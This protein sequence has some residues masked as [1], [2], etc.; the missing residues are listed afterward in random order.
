MQFHQTHRISHKKFELL[1]SFLFISTFLILSACDQTFEP[2]KEN[3]QYN[4]NISGYLDASA[5]TQWVRV[6]TVRE[7]ID[8]PPN[9][10][11][12][13]VTLEDL[14]NGE[15]VTMNDSV[16]TFKNILNYWT[17]KSIE[18]D[19]TYRIMA[20][21]SNGKTSQVTVTT[22]NEFPT[23]YITINDV[24]PVGANIYIDNTAKNI[25]DLQSVWYVIMNRGTPEQQKRI[26]RFPL[27]NT[28]SHTFAFFSSFSAFANWEEEFEHIEQNVIANS[29]VSVI[30]RQFFLAMG[31]PEWDENFASIDDLEYFLNGTG[32]NVENGL[33]YVVGIEGQW[34]K[35]EACLLPDSSNYTP[36]EPEEPF[37]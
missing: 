34:F 7:S 10:D 2:L 21:Q 11:G 3:N 36:C 20:K 8:E 1:C 13:Q 9:P 37:W 22:P 5:D 31:G 33:G 30:R 12:I 29:D 27:R 26:F 4:F 17:T 16:F 14:A 19:R 32:S 28:L 15:T 18:N 23:I 35:Q 6:G 24:S 25:V